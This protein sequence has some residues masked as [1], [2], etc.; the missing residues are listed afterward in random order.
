MLKRATLV[1]AIAALLLLAAGLA[2]LSTGLAEKELAQVSRRAALLVQFGD[3]SY[4]TRCISFDEEA[5]S[6]LE[7]LM[8]SGL[9]I[10]TWGGAV[11]RI[12]QE[13]CDYPARACFCQCQ[14]ASC[15]YWS[16]WHWRNDRWVYSQVGAADHLVRD[17]DVEA[18]L[19]G[20]AQVPPV[21]VSFAK[22]CAS[23]DVAPNGGMDSSLSED[24]DT[25]QPAIQESGSSRSLSVPIGQYVMFLGMAFGLAVGF[26]L[27]RRR[28]RE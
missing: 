21:A 27:V 20:T 1:A 24:T 19:W 14:G 26:W 23:A 6:G 13:G 3:G 15:Q 12:D 10:V 9:P 8:R 7:L 28:H 17:G 11:C 18:W 5:I 22:V 4:V 16:Y 2:F 25:G